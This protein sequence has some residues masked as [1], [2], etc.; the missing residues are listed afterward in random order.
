MQCTEAT[1]EGC[2]WFFTDPND[3]VMQAELQVRAKEH[4]TK[5]RESEAA[6]RI[7]Q[8]HKHGVM[9]ERTERIQQGALQKASEEVRQALLAELNEEKGEA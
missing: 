6:G 9:A 1:D 7:V 2:V 8:A 3:I 4:R 5:Q